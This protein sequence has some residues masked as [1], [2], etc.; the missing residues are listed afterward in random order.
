[1]HFCTG[2]IFPHVATQSCFV[3]GR[4]FIFKP[5]FYR[6]VV[7]RPRIRNTVWNI[8]MGQVR[9]SRQ[10]LSKRKQQ[11]PHSGKSKAVYDFFHIVGYQ[12]QILG[13]NG[14]GGK[15]FLDRG[16]KINGRRLLPA[17]V[18]SSCLGC[19]NFPKCYKTPEVVNAHH[20]K[21]AEVM[22]KPLYPPAVPG[23]L[24]YVPAVN[25]I[26]PELTGCAEIVRRHTG[27]AER[28]FVL[29]Q[30]EEVC[31]CPDIGAVIA[32]IDGYIANEFYALVITIIFQR[33]QLFEKQILKKFLPFNGFLKVYIYSFD[34]FSI[35]VSK[36]CLPFLPDSSLMMIFNHCKQGNILKPLPVLCTEF[37]A[38]FLFVAMVLEMLKRTVKEPSLVGYYRCIIGALSRKGRFVRYIIRRQQPLLYQKFRA[39]EEGIARKCRDAAVRRITTC[40]VSGIKRQ[41]LPV[42]LVCLGKKISKPVCPGSQVTDTKR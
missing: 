36:P 3:L 24:K 9:M 19:R 13:N 23:L 2:N 41:Y 31:M 26:S 38:G 16:K 1:M 34:T 37:F 15:C 27:D 10:I 14:N 29:I 22:G 6:I 21:K 4:C 28:P 33:M 12:S 11:N 35:P 7:M 20:I 17:P 18:K 8:I 42:A 30:F 39:Y 32:D 25:R 40:Q 5:A